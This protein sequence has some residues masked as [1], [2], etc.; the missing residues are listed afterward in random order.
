MARMDH[1]TQIGNPVEGKGIYLEDYA[2]TY[3]KKQQDTDRKK[4]YLY[5]KK[6]VTGDKERWYIYGISDSPREENRYFKNWYSLGS[7]KIRNGEKYLVGKR[8]EEIHLTGFYVFYASNQGMQEYLIDNSRGN[9]E[10]RTVSKAE[11]QGREAKPAAFGR[12]QSFRQ[13]IPEGKRKQDI[14]NMVFLAGC[15]LALILLAVAITSGNGYGKL[16]DLKE[17][18]YSAMSDSLEETEEFVVEEQTAAIFSESMTEIPE[19]T[20]AETTANTSESAATKAT[21]ET[22]ES[23]AAETEAN[24]PSDQ[25]VVNSAEMAEEASTQESIQE[26]ASSSSVI[27]IVEESSAEE[28]YESYI[29]REGDTLAGICQLYYGST[30]RLKEVC[31]YNEIKNEDHIAPGQKLYLPK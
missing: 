18:V 20:V 1:V 25:A 28:E 31:E 6:E 15:F 4:Y 14:G 12:P 21:S 23:T 22:P 2:Y 3:L 24:M 7:L 17:M 29:V 11:K 16:S 27:S 8:G 26:V 5:G 13:Y 30:A 19:S 9:K 10:E